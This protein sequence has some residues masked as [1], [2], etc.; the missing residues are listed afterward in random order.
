[1]FENNF[2]GFAFQFSEAASINFQTLLFLERKHY[3]NKTCGRTLNYI[4]HFRLK[5][6]QNQKTLFYILE[7]I[8][9]FEHKGVK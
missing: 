1:M 4:L 3:D 8:I 6:Y 7:Y 9:G 2:Q 5:K